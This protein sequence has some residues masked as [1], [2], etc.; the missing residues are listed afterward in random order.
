[1]GIYIYANPKIHKNKTNPPYR[2]I[3]SLVGNPTYN[4]SENLNMLIPYLKKIHDGS[5]LLNILRTIKTP[6][7]TYNLFTTANVE[8][9][10]EIIIKNVFKNNR[11]QP[12]QHF[13]K[14]NYVNCY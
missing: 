9:T 12:P 11:I 5:D 13:S 6:L 3:I 2:L 7:D 4:I 1:M 8:E 14:K 10:T